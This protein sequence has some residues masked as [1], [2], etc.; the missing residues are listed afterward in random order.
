MRFSI[1][2]NI[3]SISSIFLTFFRVFFFETEF[4]CSFFLLF[5]KIEGNRS[6]IDS[7][8]TGISGKREALVLLS[9]WNIKS[10]GK[11]VL[12]WDN[13]RLSRS[14]LIISVCFLFFS[15]PYFSVIFLGFWIYC[16]RVFV[17]LPTMS[18]QEHAGNE[19][20]CVWHATDFADGE[21]KDE[22]FCIRFA[23]VE[24]ESLLVYVLS[25]TSYLVW[26]ET[27]YIILWVIWL[28][29]FE[30]FLCCK[31][32]MVDS[33]CYHVCLLAWLIVVGS[34][35]WMHERNFEFF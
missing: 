23:S 32:C 6:F 1:C 29:M 8:R 9:F 7:I 28:I 27:F 20:S 5:K 2:K 14:A 19:K 17:V 22:L 31:C 34:E 13:L 18:V 15:F 21:L 30:W 16:V 10:L 24:S 26:L 25:I 33:I 4:S 3:N 12:L 11:F 35:L